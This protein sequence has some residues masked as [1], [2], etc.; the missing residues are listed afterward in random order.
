MVARGSK[1]ASSPGPESRRREVARHRNL[2]LPGGRRKQTRWVVVGTSGC[3][4]T[5]TPRYATAWK[6]RG[7]RPG[8]PATIDRV[9]TSKVVKGILWRIPFELAGRVVR[10][11]IRTGE[12]GHLFVGTHGVPPWDGIGGGPLRAVVFSLG[13]RRS[14]RADWTHEGPTQ[15]TVLRRAFLVLRRAELPTRQVSPFTPQR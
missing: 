10:R 12:A 9:R 8:N 14:P 6:P 13:G 1:G 11:V 2:D 4:L 3:R 15:T 5:T 7:A